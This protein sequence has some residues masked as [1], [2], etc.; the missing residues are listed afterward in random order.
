MP[1]SYDLA[2][3]E[4]F[5]IMGPS[6]DLA[7]PLAV[8]YDLAAQGAPFYALAAPNQRENT[9]DGAVPKA[10]PARRSGAF[11]LDVSRGSSSGDQDGSVGFDA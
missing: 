4:V 3:R 11:Q 6:Y 1:V 9:A 8:N 10:A 5:P 7:A 2:A